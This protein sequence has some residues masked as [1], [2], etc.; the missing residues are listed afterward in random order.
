MEKIFTEAEQNALNEVVEK[1]SGVDKSSGDLFD[2]AA[3]LVS[4]IADIYKAFD[5]EDPN[6]VEAEKR[7]AINT[8]VAL[9]S[10]LNNF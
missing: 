4:D 2:I 6:K 8:A 10:K 3:T 1:L 9:I 5:E 7:D